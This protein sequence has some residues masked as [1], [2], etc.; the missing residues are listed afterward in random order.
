MMYREGPAGEAAQQFHRATETEHPHVSPGSATYQWLSIGQF[1]FPVPQF[2]HLHSEGN[3]STY[4][5]RFV[6]QIK[7]TL[8]SS[9]H[10]VSTVWCLLFQGISLVL[11][12]ESGSSAS[13]F[14]FHFS[15]SMN[16]G[17]RVIYCPEGLFLY[18][19]V[20]V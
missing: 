8:K 19:S 20:P 13:S 6:V 18:G 15:H 10:M 2:P 4:F 7:C 3:N 16:L 5:I 9:S 12:I 17:E 1:T 11:L 14:Y